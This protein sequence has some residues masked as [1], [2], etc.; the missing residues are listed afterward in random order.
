MGACTSTDQKKTIRSAVKSKKVTIQDSATKIQEG[1]PVPRVDQ[2]N[3]ADPANAAEK[4]RTRVHPHHEL[5]KDDNV[6]EPWTCAG[7]QEPDGCQ[8]ESP[9]F[10]PGM[11]SRFICQNCIYYL[12]EKCTQHYSQA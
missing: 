4:V 12:C 7:E 8:D 10:Q 2:A 9:Q 3:A 1:A 5:E 6:D 11:A